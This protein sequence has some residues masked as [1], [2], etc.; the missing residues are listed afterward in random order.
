MLSPSVFVLTAIQVWGLGNII[1]SLLNLKEGDGN[2]SEGFTADY[3]APHEF[4][5]TVQSFYSPK[6]LDLV[7]KCLEYWPH[8]RPTMDDV[9]SRI[10]EATSGRRDL[11]RGLRSAP[12]ADINFA[13][14]GPKLD[15][16]KWIIGDVLPLSGSRKRKPEEDLVQP[17]T[18]PSAPED[19][20]LGGVEGSLMRP[21]SEIMDEYY[22]RIGSGS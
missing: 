6:L 22:P 1:W 18:T 13:R 16:E 11:T 9:L 8:E 20:D 12:K 17:D 15:D 2:L 14:Y 7:E 19:D 21:S 3:R 4:P 5:E 10:R